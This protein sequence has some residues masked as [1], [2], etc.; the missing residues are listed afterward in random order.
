MINLATCR[1]CGSRAIEEILNLGDLALSGVFPSP[2]EFVTKLPLNMGRCTQCG[3][4]QLMHNMP[5][6]ELYGPNYGYESNLNS[7]MR[8]HLHSLAQTA[9]RVADISRGDTV[10]DIASND[11]TLLSGYTQDGITKVGIDPLILHLN[12]NYPKDA[13]KIPDFFSSGI[14]SAVCSKKAKVVTSCS[15]FYDLDDP[16][17][18]AQNVASILSTDGVWILEQSYFYS[19]IDSLSFDTICHEH[20]LYLNLRNIVKIVEIVGL[21]VFDV[22]FNDV[23]GGSFQVY[24]QHK[25]ARFPIT[26]SVR[27]SLTE[28]SLREKVWEYE[29]TR[30]KNDVH[31]FREIFL[32]ML[33]NYKEDGRE[34]VGLGAST[35]GNVIL[36]FC[37]ITISTISEI[38]EINSKKF[39]KLTPGSNIPIVDEGS[40]DFSENVVAVI[41]PW[42][43]RKFVAEIMRTRK[44]A[45]SV[46][47]APLPRKPHLI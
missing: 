34:I 43:F 37:D 40:I 21:E 35:K 1:F 23:N 45:K 18:F 22:K 16:I 31:D 6:K 26:D 15:V 36:Q 44:Q 10:V 32:S 39:G 25:N 19:M 30:F 2:G 20:L 4:S 33:Q 13:L 28:E 3:L 27:L 12:D 7:T 29:L 46:F 5:V 47:I 24:A 14:Y 17:L 42:H 11:G 41:L 8:N 9:S 38:G